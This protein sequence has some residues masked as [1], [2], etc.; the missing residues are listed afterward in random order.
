MD[1]RELSLP[2][3][4]AMMAVAGVGLSALVALLT[5]G[6]G[7]ILALTAV[8]VVA[9]FAL[10]FRYPHQAL[11]AYAATIPL[12]T[13]QIEGLATLSRLIGA[14]FFVGYVLARRGI[15]PDAVRASAWLLVGLA[16]LSVLWTVDL[17]STFSALLTLLQLFGVTIL[18]ADA[19]S[20]EPA[21]V[22]PI[23]WSYSAAASVTA[24]LAIVAYA[25][26]R[27]LLVSDRAGAF[28][29]QDVAQF[30]ALMVPA[31]LFLMT[32]L[33]SG[34][35]R[36]LAAVG[37]TLCGVGILV[38]G[39]RS[40]WLAI[41]VALLLVVLPRMRAS[42]IVWLAI[43]GGLVVI[44]T[45]QLPGV[46]DVVTGRLETAATTGGSGRLDIWA[47]GLSI[48]GAHPLVGVG[49][50]AFPAAFT[51]D[52]I[53]SVSTP[54]LDA[55]GPVRRSCLPQHPAGDGRGTG[56]AGPAPPRVDDDGPPLAA[57]GCPVG[58]ARPGD[59][60]G[61]ADPGAVPRCS[62]SEAGLARVWAGVRTRVCPASDPTSLGPDR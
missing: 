15:R 9:V 31:F 38:S 19:V 45:L 17:T 27:D 28:A 40:A 29:Q 61:C 41:V 54:G 1:I 49:Y 11:L 7:L 56:S 22:R 48:I 21:I 30:S 37:T 53:R 44:A 6:G 5:V 60:A 32:Q 8:A 13:V 51:S 2:A 36:V 14:A 20:R 34:D 52:V 59:R 18:I 10:A 47:V 25:T 62:G 57:R 23:L 3:R 33:A 58:L 16:C 55:G 4:A 26:N 43:A 50:G 12:E 35:R 39:T 42:Q 24:I 46:A